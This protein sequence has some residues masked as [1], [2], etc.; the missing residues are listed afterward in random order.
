MNLGVES[1]L[2]QNLKNAKTSRKEAFL[3]KGGRWDFCLR[4]ALADKR[5][6]PPN[7]VK[8]KSHL[9]DDFSF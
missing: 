4:F 5:L 2:P 9:E 3:F 1:T 8:Q 7:F 6:V